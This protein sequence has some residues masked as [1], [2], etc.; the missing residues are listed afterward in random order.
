MVNSGASSRT[1]L[2]WS[3]TCYWRIGKGRLSRR[4]GKR[5]WSSRNLWDRMCMEG[6]RR[7]VPLSGR[8]PAGGAGPCW[9][10]RPMRTP[11]WPFN[12]RTLLLLLKKVLGIDV[13]T[14]VVLLLMRIGKAWGV[15]LLI[16]LLVLIRTSLLHRIRSATKP[17]LG[18]MILMLLLLIILLL[19]HIMLL[20]WERWSSISS[21]S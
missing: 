2:V 4:M 9:T 1:R 20:L 14:E 21:V 19:L 13:G 10:K 7:V 15:L 16:L 12:W 18:L 8:A 5:G 11:L 3:R 17:L 6:V